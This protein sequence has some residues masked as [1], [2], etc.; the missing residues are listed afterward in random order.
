MVKLRQTIRMLIPLYLVTTVIIPCFAG[1]RTVVMAVIKSQDIKPYNIALEGFNKALE[2]EGIKALTFN[3][4]MKGWEEEGRKIAQEVISKKPDIVLTLGTKATRIALQDIKDFPVVFSAVLNPIDS[5]LVKS[6]KCS[7]NN[8]TGASVDIPVKTQ[9]EWLKEVV[10]NVK[11]I[12]VL[13]NPDETKV[14]INDA[15][16]IAETMKLKLIAVPVYSQKDVP[17][18]TKDLVRKIDA[19]WAVADSTVFIPQSTKFILL[20]T[21]RMKIPFMGLSSGFVNIG[22]LLA[23]SCNYEDIGRQSGELAVRI[24]AGEKPSTIP[25]TVPRKTFLSLNLR[26]ARQIGLNIPSHIVDKAHEVF[27]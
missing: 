13:Y 6:L 1:E 23:L 22:A 24:L 27:R 7:G 10:P 4:D 9:F 17:K 14:V 2:E 15:S 25:I 11:K 19:L 21:L 12:G 3:Y 8:L 5:G 18:A 20:H 16:K 26:V